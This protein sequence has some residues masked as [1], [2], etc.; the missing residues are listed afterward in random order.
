MQLDE[1]G[2]PGSIPGIPG[3]NVDRLWAG[4]GGYNDLSSYNDV[5]KTLQA[6]PG[7]L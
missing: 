1:D 5:T 7:L 2:T 3:W 4:I 6:L